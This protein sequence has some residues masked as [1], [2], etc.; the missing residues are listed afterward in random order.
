MAIEAGF[1]FFLYAWSSYVLDK[2]GVDKKYLE[3]KKEV[4]MGPRDI[5]TEINQIGDDEILKL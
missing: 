1:G 5:L 3:F 4:Y 2:S